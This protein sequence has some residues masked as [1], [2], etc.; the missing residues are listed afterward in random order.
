MP[1][2][3]SENQFPSVHGQ[4]AQNWI[5]RAVII[6]L[7][8]IAL[9]PFVLAVSYIIP[10]SVVGIFGS[11]SRY[12]LSDEPSEGHNQ[13]DRSSGD[14][15]DWVEKGPLAHL[16]AT[17][18]GRT[19]DRTLIFKLMPAMVILVSTVLALLLWGMSSPTTANLLAQLGARPAG[20]DGMERDAARSLEKLSLKAGLSP[21]KLYIIQCSFPTTFSDSKDIRNAVVAVTSGALELLDAQELETLLAHELFHIIN[22]DSQLTDILAPL[23]VVTEYPFRLFRG[24]MSPD[25]YNQRSVR[26][27]LALLELALSPLGLYVFFIAPILN[28]FISAVVLRDREFKA[29]AN[30]AS[31]TANP[32]GLASALAKIGGVDTVLEKTTV[33]NLPAHTSLT[34]RIEHLMSLYS[35]SEFKGVEAAIARGKRY[36]QDRPGMGEDKP[37]LVPSSSLNQ[38]HLMGRVY[39]LVSHVSEPVFDKVG[40]GALLMTQVKPGALLVAFDTPGKMR[41]VNTAEEVFGYMSRDVKLQAVNGVLPQEVYDPKARAAAEEALRRQ[42]EQPTADLTRQHVWIALGFGTAVFAGT[43]IILIVFAGH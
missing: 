17:V 29:D 13:K 33:S 40:P 31:L 8:A 1:E 2:F 12:F 16:G 27:K 3:R 11:A 19:S 20:S 30:A 10:A 43:T 39:R 34:I 42:G 23:A 36:A 35:T 4:A 37:G 28:H 38:G 41:Q 24:K 5:N 22:R 6:A 7:T 21:P 25:L 18:A 9:A 14:P 26:Q 15:L 32:P